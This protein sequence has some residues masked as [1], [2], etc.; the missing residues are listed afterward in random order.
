MNLKRPR[1]VD[2]ALIG[3]FE[4]EFHE[5]CKT[6]QKYELTPYTA[7]RHPDGFNLQIGFGITYNTTGRGNDKLGILKDIVVKRRQ[8]VIHF[9]V[10]QVLHSDDLRKRKCEYAGLGLEDQEVVVSSSY[11]VISIDD[12]TGNCAILTK[13]QYRFFLKDNQI[14]HNTYFYRYWVVFQKDSYIAF[15]YRNVTSDL[16][17]SIV[18]NLTDKGAAS[19]SEMWQQNLLMFKAVQRTLKYSGATR[20]VSVST[21]PAVLTAFKDTLEEEEMLPSKTTNQVAIYDSFTH[22]ARPNRRPRAGGEKPLTTLSSFFGSK[23]WFQR[24]DG[25]VFKFINAPE[26][27]LMLDFGRGV[28]L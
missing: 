8:K 3:Q 9:L 26:L 11:E 22:D 7:L 6:H 2:A 4:K 23:T 27:R 5:A 13:E 24:T 10:Q 25:G 17:G 14:I 16:K 18:P 12:A 19:L 21:T 28:Y 1:K 20:V 15:Q